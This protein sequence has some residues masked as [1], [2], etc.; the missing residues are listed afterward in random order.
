MSAG[1]P[2][3]RRW[4]DTLLAWYFVS[5]WGSGFV[6]TKIGIQY[7]AP[8]TFLS[9]RFAFGLI[10]MIPIVLIARP[11]WPAN[12]AELLVPIQIISAAGART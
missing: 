2:T 8:F 9:L 5:V 7:A 6:A 10:C 3:D 11:V 4:L 12:R 1:A